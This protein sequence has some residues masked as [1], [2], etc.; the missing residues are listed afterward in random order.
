MDEHEHE[1]HT[2]ENKRT[3]PN[4]VLSLR[5]Y[6]IASSWTQ[7]SWAI[8]FSCSL[9]LSHSFYFSIPYSLS[10]SPSCS[11]F[12]STLPCSQCSQPAQI[13]LDKSIV[14]LSTSQWRCGHNWRFLLHGKDYGP[15]IW[16]NRHEME[17]LLTEAINMF[18]TSIYYFLI[19][20][21]KVICAR[22]AQ[23]STSPNTVAN[24]IR[25]KSIVMNL[26]RYFIFR[27]NLICW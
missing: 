2:G 16:L 19:T 14:T 26:W 7:C 9:P 11:F 10:L 25:L 23:Q 18:A 1:M 12:L 6:T 20:C 4:G 8:A 3:I 17:L 21:N 22:L 13:W 5:K 27:C 24:N 15:C